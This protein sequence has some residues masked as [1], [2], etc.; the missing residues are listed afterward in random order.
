MRDD[1]TI[2]VNSC[3]KYEDAWN[4]FFKIFKDEWPECSYPVILNTEYKAYD[5]PYM[6]VKTVCT[7]SENSWTARVR[8]IVSET[9]TKYY[10]LI[11]EDFFFLSPVNNS[12]FEKSFEL[13]KNDESIGFLEYDPRGCGIHGEKKLNEMFYEWKKHKV[14]VNAELALWR[15]EFLLEMLF[16]DVDPWRFELNSAICSLYSKYKSAYVSHEYSI[17]D[18]SINPKYGYGITAGKWLNKNEELFKKHSVDVNFNNIGVMKS[19]VTYSS[20]RIQRSG[21]DDR[22]KLPLLKRIR[23]FGRDI[24]RKY[25]KY[26]ANKKLIKEFKIY[27]K[28]SE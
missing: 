9:D 25:R 21:L 20:L 12:L 10:L 5:C 7:G 19:D 4:P 28:S 23:L 26:K 8:K 18:Y 3:D 17:F 16:L 11:L 22:G 1:I 6:N 24:I 2:I 27:L 14:R 13:M 15:R